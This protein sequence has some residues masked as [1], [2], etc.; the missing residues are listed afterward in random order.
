MINDILGEPDTLEDFD[1]LFLNTKHITDVKEFSKLISNFQ[2]EITTIRKSL[3]N[4][5]TVSTKSASGTVLQESSNNRQSL[6][7][8]N[9]ILNK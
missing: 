9:Q 4:E 1:N 2:D 5:I 7:F 6:L 8:L 3:S